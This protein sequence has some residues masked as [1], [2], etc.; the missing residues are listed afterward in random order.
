MQ[1][2]YKKQLENN[3][4]LYYGIGDYKLDSCPKKQTMVIPKCYST[5]VAA[6]LPIAASKKLSEKQKVT[7]LFPRTLH[8][9][10]SE[11][12]IV[13]LNYFHFSSHFI[14]FYLFIF[15]FQDSELEFNMTSY[16]TVTNCHISQKDDNVIQYILH[17]L[18]L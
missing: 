18:I 1:H 17:I 10:M 9:L 4:Y 11:S 15:L 14:L 3:L 7:F 12:K 2:K 5:L 16:I 6:N 13:D 8:R